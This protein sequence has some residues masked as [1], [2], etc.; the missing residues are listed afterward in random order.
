MDPRARLTLNKI[1]SLAESVVQKPS[2]SQDVNP[3]GGKLKKQIFSDVR[4]GG[5]LPMPNGSTRIPLKP[6]VGQKSLL[7]T[8]FSGPSFILE[9]LK[10]PHQ[11]IT[12]S[13]TAALFLLTHHKE[14]RPFLCSGDRTDTV[15][16]LKELLQDWSSLMPDEIRLLLPQ[17][18]SISGQHEIY[19]PINGLGP[20]PPLNSEA[21][22]RLRN[23]RRYAQ[24]FVLICKGGHYSVEV[25][26]TQLKIR[27]VQS[28]DSSQPSKKYQLKTDSR[29]PHNRRQEA[30]TTAIPISRFLA[31][32]DSAL[33]ARLTNDLRIS[34]QFSRTNFDRLEG[35]G[36]NG[37]LPSLGKR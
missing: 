14:L 17:D 31:M 28:Q 27:R 15:D 11:P 30:R 3:R 1:T 13:E 29:V 9:L 6:R 32:F 22:A 23:R 21:V 35:W 12:S 18:C 7:D 10:K 24:D 8:L 37:G 19:L 34:Q 20:L 4:T 25:R 26:F 36:V 16:W 5:I 33:K 2:D